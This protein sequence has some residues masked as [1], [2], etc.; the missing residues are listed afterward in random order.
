MRAPCLHAALYLM[1][2]ET[3]HVPCES[4]ECADFF[5][6]QDKRLTDGSSF[7]WPRADYD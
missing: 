6:P 1:A 7:E 4:E 5:F 2:G 3:K